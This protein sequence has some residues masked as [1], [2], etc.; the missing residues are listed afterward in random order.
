M[1]MIE[2]ESHNLRQVDFK[3]RFITFLSKL[4]PGMPGE[5]GRN[6]F[7]FFLKKSTD[8]AVNFTHNDVFQGY[9]LQLK[10]KNN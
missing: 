6:I 1:E 5:V 4:Y 8:C 7:N 9:I 3:H 2:K 10:K